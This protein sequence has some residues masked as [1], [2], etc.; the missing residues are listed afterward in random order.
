MATTTLTIG[1]SA[2]N[3]DQNNLWPSR[4]SLRLHGYS[5]LTLVRRGFGKLPGLPDPWL[6]KTVSLAIDSTTYFKG[7]VVDFEPEYTE[8]GWTIS[9]QCRDLRFRGDR[10]PYTDS[11]TLTDSGAWNLLGDDRDWIASRAG[12]TI[13]EVLEAVLTMDANATALDAMGIGG[14]TSSSPWTLPSATTTDLAALSTIPPNPVSV[15]G[16]RLLT[17]VESFLNAWAPNHSMWIRPSDG[18]IRFLDRRSVTNHTLTLETDP[19][20]PTPLR[21]SV[22]DCYQRVV[23]RGQ[24]VAEPKLLTLSSGGLA[25]DFAYGSLDNAGAKAAYNTAD[26]LRDLWNPADNLRNY[27]DRFGYI[28]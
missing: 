2:V 8:T 25:E 26:S 16:E 7:D 24:P 23:V 3:M 11:N 9:Y 5:T 17:A 19:I 6:G 18:V 14:Y 27:T 13:G 10:A 1:G 20:S 12:K 4:M 21:R 28:P 15:Q 22:T